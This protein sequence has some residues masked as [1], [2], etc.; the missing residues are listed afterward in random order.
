MMIPV[1]FDSFTL[2]PLLA[3]IATA[4]LVMLIEA[5]VKTSEKISYWL[6]ICGLVVSMVASFATMERSGV[7]LQQMINVGGMGSLFSIMFCISAL[8]TIVLARDYLE[9][10]GAH[11]G[12][13]YLLILFAT[14]G[15]VLMAS[16]ADLI[17]IFLGLELM[18]ICLYVLAG[19]MR[20]RALSNESA[21][22]YFLLGSFATGFLLYGIALVYGAAGSTKISY[23]IL[24][25]GVVSV[26][27]FFWIGIGFLFIGLAF[28]VGGVPF[29]M[30]IPDVY[31]GAPTPVTGFM[32]TGAKAAAFSAIILVFLTPGTLRGD[33]VVKMIAVVSS[34]SMIAGNIIAIS[35]SNLKRML[36]FSSIAH[37]GYLLVGIASNNQIGK[38][39]VIFYLFCYTFMNLG[40]FGILSL[41]EREEKNLTFDDYSGFG[42]RHPVIAAFMSI[43]LFSLAGIPPFAGFFG[44]YY[45]FVAAIDAGL[46]W[47]AI[48]GV[49]MS[50]V[51]VYYYLRLIV[52][53]YFREGDQ[54]LPV[55][56]S[57]ASY[58]VII[59]CVLAIIGLGIYPS[60]LL[61]I[62]TKF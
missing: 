18:S 26:S 20:K 19:Y 52:V 43:F 24:N 23:L 62:I 28:K 11:Y 50:V 39:G 1:E 61:S 34:L 17:I 35:Q 58:A 29:H 15:M 16:A 37:A 59:I 53:M 21:L 44:K 32:S 6:S 9:R 10:E 49:L 12:E 2:A 7:V 45:V 36:A 30:W 48:L 56:I 41:M 4:L 38:N 40:A 47:L 27:P 31:Q 54:Q 60:S 13:F 3:L 55:K 5:F 46:T 42:F 14:I 8:G 51:S 33:G 22:K 25:Y 57:N